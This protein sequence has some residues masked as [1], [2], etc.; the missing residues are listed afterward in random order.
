VDFERAGF[1]VGHAG[2]AETRAE[3]AGVKQAQF[4]EGGGRIALFVLDDGQRTVLEIGEDEVGF[5]GFEAGK[6]FL[7]FGCEGETALICRV[8]PRAQPGADRAS[9]TGRSTEVASLK[10]RDHASII[11]RVKNWIRR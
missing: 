1:G 4:G 5:D 3:D 6:L 8:V 10:G 9:N 2:L 11:E 7:R